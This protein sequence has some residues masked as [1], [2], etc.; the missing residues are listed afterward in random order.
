MMNQEFW[1]D[2]KVFLTGHTGFKGSWLALWLSTLGAQITG[3]ALKPPTNPNLFELAHVEEL[4]KHIVGD[5][6]D[7]RFLEKSL[8]EAKPDIVIH[9]AA[10]PL[11]R[12]SYKNPVETYEINIMGTIYLLEAVR[13]CNTV[14][15][16]VNVTTDKCYKNNEWLWG[17]RENEPMGGHD[18]Y[19]NSKACSELITDSYR[20]SFFSSAIPGQNQVAVASA[21]AGNVIGGGDW[22]ADRLIPDCLQ[23][24]LM[25]KPIRIRSPH[26]VRPWQ[27]VLE[28]LSGYLL[29]AEKLFEEGD[30]FATG[31]N[32]GPGED[33]S[34]PVEAIVKILCRL[35]GANGIY[36]VDQ[37]EHPHEANYLRLD[38][39][40]ARTMLKWQPRWNLTTALEETIEWI[41]AYQNG[42]D[43][44]L[45]CQGQIQK[46]MQLNEG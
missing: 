28:P 20:N 22:A 13:A 25:N 17:Y 6:R 39:S 40:K 23:S 27:H 30:S 32:F 3:Y 42:F 37:G 10:Q 35:W 45:I 15:A 7:K 14:R 8:L 1:K 12:D 5:V 46:Y 43:M 4:V 16:V 38:C 21:R 34:L 9:L 18:P 41:K 44:R 36:E 2:K 11:V 19:S 29:L 24:L 26:A 33:D 31:W